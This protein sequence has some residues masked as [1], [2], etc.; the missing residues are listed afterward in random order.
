MHDKAAGFNVP[1]GHVG[2]EGT[3]AVRARDGQRAG[4]GGR[5][6]GQG[7]R[8]RFVIIDYVRIRLCV[9][10]D[11]CWRRWLRRCRWS[12]TGAGGA[13]GRA[14]VS[15]VSLGTHTFMPIDARGVELA[16]ARRAG[17]AFLVHGGGDGQ[18]GWYFPA[19]V[20]GGGQGAAIKLRAGLDPRH[21]GGIVGIKR[22]VREIN[23]GTRMHQGA[24]SGRGRLPNTHVVVGG[25]Q[26][27]HHQRLHGVA[28]RRRDARPCRELLGRRFKAQARQE[29]IGGQRGHKRTRWQR[30]V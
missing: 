24:K 8:V 6:K 28:G 1:R 26:G 14:G 12:G 13:G 23:D 27:D 2:P 3:F 4:T 7:V 21:H 19:T 11:G 10:S 22:R 30:F 16:P 15:C 25:V 18:H 5:R 9:M 17:H 20:C 29:P